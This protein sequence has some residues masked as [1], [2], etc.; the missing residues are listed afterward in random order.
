[1]FTNYNHSSSTSDDSDQNNTNLNNNTISNNKQIKKILPP[2][3]PNS[4]IANNKSTNEKK[5]SNEI[6]LNS[7]KNI[8]QETSVT[9]DT[10]GK[11]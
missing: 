1:M 5:Q 10:P 4:F 2:S 8:I 9:L 6:Y 3:L 11:S 7:S